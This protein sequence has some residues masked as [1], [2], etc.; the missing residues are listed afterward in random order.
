MDSGDY[1]FKDIL[2]Q[3][4]LGRIEKLD[5]LSKDR[6]V[7]S[8]RVL[9]KPSFLFRRS[10]SFLLKR[11]S[12]HDV[13]QLRLANNFLLELAKRG[14]V[15]V[16]APLP[17][18]QDDT[19]V[20]AE[21]SSYALFRLDRIVFD[22]ASLVS[23]F[24]L[25]KIVNAAR[26]LASFHKQLSILSSH[27]VFE[28][29]CFKYDEIAHIF[30]L[31]DSIR[32]HSPLTVVDKFL[33]DNIPEF[34]PHFKAYLNDLKHVRRRSETQLV[35][36]RFTPR[37]LLFDEHDVAALLDAEGM[38]FD[39]VEYDL[40]SAIPHFVKNDFFEKRFDLDT[41]KRFLEA[42][43]SVYSDIFLEPREV[44][45]FLRHSRL[46][47]AALA[48]KELGFDKRSQEVYGP[49]RQALADL[50]AIESQQEA[51]VKAFYDAGVS[52]KD[53]L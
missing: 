47:V 20:V 50:V 7:E 16:A 30:N 13:S 33:L 52:S 26:A 10:G 27:E 6:L 21:D 25:E 1:T 31:P 22:H 24:S 8:Y 4:G 19:V 36:G 35:H 12:S 44:L 41:L 32:E 38:R 53:Y 39:Y 14:G 3:Y 43:R 17:T 11:Y 18:K 48:I 9:V 46:R 45:V 5:L 40:V 2:D 15:P 23:G 42:Y 51:L 28:A 34:W 37:S 29:Q 49:V